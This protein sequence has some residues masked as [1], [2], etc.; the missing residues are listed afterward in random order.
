MDKG[1]ILVVEDEASIRNCLS[2]LLEL[3][4]FAS[5]VA[6]DGFQAMSLLNSGKRAPDAILLDLMMPVCSGY[7]F[8]ELLNGFPDLKAIP[9]IIISAAANAEETAKAHHL[10]AVRKPI[11][12][13]ELLKVLESVLTRDSL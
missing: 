4:G 12:G 6:A 9:I 5:E 11:D 3:E 13:D 8:L 2:E 7:A 1:L 10:M